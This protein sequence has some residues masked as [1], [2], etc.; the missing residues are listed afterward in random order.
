MNDA[1]QHLQAGQTAAAQSRWDVALSEFSASNAAT[2]SIVAKEGMANAHF[3]LHHD[4][5]ARAAYSEILSMNV[6]LPPGDV[7]IQQ[8]W[9][10]TRA[11]AQDRVTAIDARANAPAPMLAQPPPPPARTR[12][13]DDADEDRPHH[14][15]RTAENSVFFEVLGN[16]LLY[17]INY[18][19]IIGDSGFSIRGGFSYFSL[20]G[21]TTSG[22]S[23]AGGS[24]SAKF[25]LITLPVLGNYY[26]GSDNHKLQLGIGLTFMY[27]SATAGSSGVGGASFSGFV[28]APTAAIGYRYIPADGGFAFFVGLTPFIIPGGDK[29]L[30]PWGGISFG[31]VF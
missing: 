9:A 14:K 31:G 17:S 7:G 16:G 21:G 22:S 2:P 20:S 23:A 13:R 27:T 19:R 5:E 1:T 24:T 30:V 6:Q 10:R 11:T 26:V 25:S 28:P 29:T 15:I 8:A 12:D 18:E 4:R 3:E